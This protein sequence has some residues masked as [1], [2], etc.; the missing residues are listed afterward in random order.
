MSKVSWLIAGGVGFLLGSR[1]GREPYERF[2]AQ[3]ESIKGNPRV[4]RRTE[5]AKRTVGRKADE[6]VDKATGTDSATEQGGAGS[7]GGI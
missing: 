1:A 7:G 2:V 3:V 6:L 5:E 4:Q